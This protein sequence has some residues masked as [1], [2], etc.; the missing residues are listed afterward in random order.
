ME[1]LIKEWSD[2]G[3]LTLSNSAERKSKI[4]ALISSGDPNVRV[5]AGDLTDRVAMLGDA[6]ARVSLIKRDLAFLVLY[7]HGRAGVL[8]PVTEQRARSQLPKT[9]N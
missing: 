7:V 1:Q 9:D 3:R 2:T 4:A 5:S 6:R 8:C